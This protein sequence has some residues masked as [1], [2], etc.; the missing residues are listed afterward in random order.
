MLIPGSVSSNQLLMTG[1]LSNLSPQDAFRVVV[2]LGNREVHSLWKSLRTKMLTKF[3]SDFVDDLTFDYTKDADEDPDPEDDVLVSGALDCWFEESQQETLLR[4]LRQ[5]RYDAESGWKL[6]ADQVLVKAFQHIDKQA[7]EAAT[8]KQTCCDFSVKF[9]GLSR[10]MDKRWLGVVIDLD[11]FQTYIIK[12]LA[13]YCRQKLCYTQ[14]QVGF[15]EA[16][17]NGDDFE[18]GRHGGR[19]IHRRSVHHDWRPT[20]EKLHDACRVCVVDRWGKRDFGAY[21][22]EEYAVLFKSRNNF[23][24]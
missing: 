8:C 1:I 5:G 18:L 3:V 7:S 13:C 12:R 11:A 24:S 15:E 22:Q 16:D 6:F 9:T 10:T 20:P 14:M 17:C 2:S 4:L 21:T 19:Q 23:I